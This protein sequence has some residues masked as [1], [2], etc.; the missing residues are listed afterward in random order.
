MSKPITNSGTSPEIARAENGTPAIRTLFHSSV[1]CFVC[2]EQIH[3]FKM[4][5]QKND[6]FLCIYV[7]RR[8]CN[9]HV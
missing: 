5:T 8:N 7:I 3:C 9:V 1:K 6:K 4:L 2:K